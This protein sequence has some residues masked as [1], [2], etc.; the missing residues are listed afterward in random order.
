MDKSY[1]NLLIPHLEDVEGFSDKVYYDQNK[2]PTVG[3]GFNL[4]S[5][6]TVNYLKNHGISVEDVY[7]NGMNKEVA[8]KIKR[9]MIPQEEKKLRDMHPGIMDM[10]APNEQAAVMSLFYNNPKLVGPS[11]RGYLASGDKLNAAKEV[12]LKSN[13]DKDLGIAFRRM[14][15][16]ELLYPKM[17]DI[18]KIMT[19]EEK[20]ELQSILQNSKNENVKRDIY[21]RYGNSLGLVPAP[22]KF[23]KLVSK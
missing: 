12:L 2:N 15:E 21:N 11:L 8:S 23:N 3:Y 4:N 18:A 6:D 22:V 19:P 17:E 7:K 14:K 5:G 13:K 10:L 9:A 20:L 16:S 1:E